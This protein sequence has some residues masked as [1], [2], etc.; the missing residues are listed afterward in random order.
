M[1]A[2]GTPFRASTDLDLVY[3]SNRGQR[4]GEQVEEQQFF[5]RGEAGD[6]GVVPEAG[7]DHP[8]FGHLSS[9]YLDQPS[10]VDRSTR[11]LPS[12]SPPPPAS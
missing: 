1:I 3:A 11:L 10:S 2:S 12:V 9:R 4:V 6:V 7:V 8:A 5:A